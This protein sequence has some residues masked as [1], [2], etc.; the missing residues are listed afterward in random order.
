MVRAVEC[1]GGAACLLAR[2]GLRQ[3]SHEEYREER[4]ERLPGLAG[5]LEASDG[6]HRCPAQPFLMA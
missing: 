2:T 5:C 4:Q 3:F 1:C 6:L